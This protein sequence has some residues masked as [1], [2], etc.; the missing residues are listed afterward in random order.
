M[1]NPEHKEVLDPLDKVS[2]CMYRLGISVFSLALLGYVFV[3]L[4]KA[5]LLSL[6][7]Q[8]EHYT[9]LAVGVSTALSA[10]NVHVYSKWVRAAITYSGWLGLVLLLSDIELI[11]V[12]W[13]LGFVFVTFSGIALKE[14][15]C[16]KVVGLKVV[17]VLLA[18]S[19]PLIMLELWLA[20]AALL[21]VSGFIL[22][23]LSIVKWQMPLHFDIGIKA[24]YEI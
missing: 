12:W 18:I 1:A 6:P 2:V 3:L 8:F 15:F 24:R 22:G 5:M 9:L 16:F 11:R 21:G 4:E 10:A 19:V 23:Y 17:P 20:C 13:S 14:S 7:N